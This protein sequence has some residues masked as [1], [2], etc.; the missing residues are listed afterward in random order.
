MTKPLTHLKGVGKVSAETLS[1]AGVNTVADILLLLPREYE[2][3]QNP[4]PFGEVLKYPNQTGFVNT[5]VE[6]IAH[7]YIGWGKKRTLKIYVKDETSVASLV[8]F[9]RNF[10]A[11][12]ILPGERYRLYGR[13]Q[14]RYGELQS[15][16]FDLEPFGAARSQ[17]GRILPVYPL[18][19]NLTQ[20]FMRK[21][22][23]EAVQ[24]FGVYAENELPGY[25]KGKRKIIEKSEALRLVH[26][27][28]SFASVG[29][30]KRSLIYE[31]LFY[32]QLVILR[33][34]LKHRGSTREAAKLPVTQRERAESRLPFEL[35]P[36]QKTAIEEIHADLTGESPMNRLL[37]GDVGSGK[38]L[39]ALLSALPVI[40]AGYQA[41][42]MAPTELLALQH[43]EEAH[44]L[45]KPLGIR[46]AFLSGSTHGEPRRHL[47]ESLRSGEIDLVVGTHALFSEHVVFQ[48]LRYAIIDEQ[49]RFGVMQRLA[50]T[51]KGLYPDI[52]LMTATPIPRTLTLTVLGDLDTSTIKTMPP[53]RKPV[54]TH[55]AVH[56]REKKVYDHV[57]KELSEG[58]Q[59]YFVYPL[60]EESEK[61]ALRDAESMYAHLS[62][63]V[64]PE[65]EIA[66]IHSRLCEEERTR[67]MHAFADGKLD[68]LVATSV[69][70]VGVN[71][72]NATCMV[73]EH[74]ERFGLST[75]HQLRGRVGRS[76]L[77]SYMFCVYGENPTEEAK[78]RL[79]IMMEST[80]G[81]FIAEEDLKL[82]G[83][84]N[85]A[86]TNQSGYFRLNVADPLH[87]MEI[88]IEAREDAKEIVEND[89][90]LLQPEHEILRTVLNEA[91]P[92]SADILASG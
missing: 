73:V 59:A 76:E 23:S 35:T 79:K 56:G 78:H 14:Y 77:Q 30:A 51:R 87:H 85:V 74:A 39:V 42:L 62:K 71:V 32:L 52:L 58:R 27:P 65:F 36:D 64:F 19:G 86:G 70:E 4:I 50:L 81:F 53:G 55:L 63:E 80:D 1:A 41:A 48:N 11:N 46:T 6:V 67:I 68:A 60:I 45:L 22:L 88:L 61:T 72:P 2:D 38:T 15:T 90:G 5:A 21:A 20:G 8:C 10:L 92:F 7:D 28:D 44:R 34:S 18:T 24:A 9:G 49:Q 54:R 91:P 33:N 69:V 31:E 66:L 29:T 43:A 89:P 26:F 16:G 84:G 47:L 37:Q 25:L 57:R 3:R 17:F 83:P 75:L 12:K 13:F 40:E 82:R